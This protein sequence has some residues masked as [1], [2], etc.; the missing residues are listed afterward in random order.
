MH[1]LVVGLTVKWSFACAPRWGVALAG[2]IS[3]GFSLPC[4]G[5]PLSGTGQVQADGAP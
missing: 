1:R 3:T 5:T 2:F 4:R